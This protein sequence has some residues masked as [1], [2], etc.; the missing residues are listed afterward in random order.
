[1]ANA[2][3][4]LIQGFQRSFPRAIEN[5]Q[6]QQLFD[7]KLNLQKEQAEQKRL[8]LEA[9]RKR[10]EDSLGALAS[11][12]VPPEEKVKLLL[13]PNV[14]AAFGEFQDLT[15]PPERKFR[16]FGDKT[17]EQIGEQPID[18]TN[19]VFQEPKKFARFEESPEGLVGITREGETE[20]I[21]DTKNLIERKPSR[22]TVGFDKEGNKNLFIVYDNGETE[23]INTGLTDKGKVNN[24]EEFEKTLNVFYE[25][26]DDIN[27]QKFNY[28]NNVNDEIDSAITNFQRK[29]INN[30]ILEQERRLYNVMPDEARTVINRYYTEIKKD[31]TKGLKFLDTPEARGDF[32]E[33]FAQ[34]HNVNKNEIANIVNAWA[35]FKFGYIRS[36]GDGIEN[37]SPNPQNKVKDTSQSGF[38]PAT[39]NRINKFMQDN[40]ISDRNEAIKILKENNRL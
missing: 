40:G 18:F 2:V 35:N 14:R 7:K 10:K 30:K 17:F 32:A 8:G 22:S 24:T 28:L 15:A 19:P 20:L 5:F 26:N 13:D 37:R 29:A 3:K 34:N 4:Q 9:E 33:W 6:R 11:D 36:E 31:K 39:S 38:D 23:T 27:K 25:A 12:L 1:M 16:T 21:P